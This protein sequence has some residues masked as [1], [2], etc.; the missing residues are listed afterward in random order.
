MYSIKEN[1]LYYDGIP[2]KCALTGKIL[3]VDDLKSPLTDEV[4][5]SPQDLSNFIYRNLYRDM[6]GSLFCKEEGQN[7]RQCADCGKVYHLS[8]MKETEDGWV[9]RRCYE[10]HYRVCEHC[11]R[12]VH[13]D[14]GRSWIVSVRTDSGYFDRDEMFLCED[15]TGHGNF[16]DSDYRMC[17]YC[18][19]LY[20]AEDSTTGMCPRC[21]RDLDGDIIHRYHYRS[22]PG[23]G[24]K[25]LGIE[26]REQK[27][28]FGIELE[29]DKGGENNEKATR[30]REKIGKNFVVACH[31]GSLY[32]GFELV[33]CPANLENHL[34]IIN[35]KAGMEE[36]RR[37]GYI[38]H[39]GGRCGLHVHIDRQF[40]GGADVQEDTEAKFFISFRNNLDWIKLFSRRFYYDYCEVN[41]YERRND[42][43]AD[44]YGKILYPPDKI[45]VMEKK[46]SGNRHMALNFQPG[47]TIEI[48]IFRGT[49]NYSTFVATLQFV[50]LWSNFIKD[51]S[52]NVIHQL[53]L[54]NFLR[55]AEN[56][57]YN[58]FI[59]Y[60]RDRNIIEGTPTGY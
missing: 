6:F 16:E 33:S 57:G 19:D 25:F 8:R 1:I 58:E 7:L 20:L 41:G 50:E 34:H 48:R 42:G 60:L 3:I 10:R 27:P 23:Y 55:C 35:W 32:N 53:R 31:D 49:L 26:T 4:T 52:Y 28:L 47:N 37:L 21:N 9:C 46:Q 14:H 44:S 45:W 11:G 59:S 39:D 36:A 54:E 18:S 56:R 24:M 51:N 38:S 12:A 29:V 30:V 43:S 13:Y 15:C 40:F 2:L 17:R 22:D 5:A